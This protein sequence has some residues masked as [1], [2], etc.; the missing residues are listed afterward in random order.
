MKTPYRILLG[1]L[2]ILAPHLTMAQG[3][4]NIW[5][6]GNGNGLDFNFSPPAMLEN[7][8]TALGALNLEGVGSIADNNGA[9]LFYTD[10]IEVF[11][12][13]HVEMPSTVTANL[14]GG[15]GSS[16]QSGMILPVN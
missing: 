5:Y 1:F 13:T 4:A 9:L 14:L 11:T 6:F 2:I 7:G 16:T 12:K 3:Q 10:G 8:N 15:D